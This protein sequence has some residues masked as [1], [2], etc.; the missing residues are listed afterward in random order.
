MY[1][2]HDEVEM[3]V[4]NLA[5][6]CLTGPSGP[7]D[8]LYFLNEARDWLRKVCGK[9]GKWDALD[10]KANAGLR[11]YSKAAWILFGDGFNSAAEQLL[12]ECWNDYG[13]RQIEED[14]HIWRAPI[15][16]TLAR[17]YI[18]TDDPGAALRWALLAYADE[19]LGEHKTKSRQAKEALQTVLGMS[20][21]ALVELD[22]VNGNMVL[23]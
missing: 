10:D 6:K 20:D 11:A 16:M 23:V 5:H 17:W 12:F 2:Y 1:D 18:R 7:I 22:Q 19:A 8:P 9:G 15:A 4:A 14:Q 3:E 13:L 21:E